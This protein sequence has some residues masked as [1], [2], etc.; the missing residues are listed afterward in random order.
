MQ[1]VTEK[2]YDFELWADMAKNDPERFEQMRSEA[3]DEIIQSTR[4]EQ[5]MQ[6]RRLQ[7]RIDRIR[8]RAGTPLAATL[9]ISKLMWESFNTLKD[10]F[11]SMFDAGVKPVPAYAVTPRKTADIVEFKLRA[12]E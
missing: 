8:E 11:E 2:E 12:V 10:R 5:Q 3:I 1:L 7:W 9:A 6:L 4:G